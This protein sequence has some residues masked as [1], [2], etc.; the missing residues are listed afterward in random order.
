MGRPSN[1]TSSSSSGSR[2][3][4]LLVCLLLGQML[5]IGTAWGQLRG[6][7]Q[8]VIENV[9]P[10]PYPPDYSR[11]PVFYTS[12]G[13]DYDAFVNEYFMRNL[14]VDATG[15]YF[16]DDDTFSP[17]PG[18]TGV[19]EKINWDA[20]FLPWVDT[21]AMGLQRQPNGLPSN[22]NVFFQDRTLTGLLQTGMG[23]FGYTYNRTGNWLENT[24]RQTSGNAFMWSWPAY[25]DND[26]CSPDPDGDPTG[27]EFQGGGA[28]PAE[29][30]SADFAF[31]DNYQDN[32]LSGTI[33]GPLNRILTPE[34]DCEV[35]HLPL[36][37]IDIKYVTPS[38]LG[39]DELLDHF[40][41]YW[42]RDIDAGFSE[43]RSVGIDFAVA[44]PNDFPGMFVWMVD[45]DSARYSLHFPM[46]LHPEW[47]HRITQ[48]MIKPVEE[49]A[50]VDA[51]GTQVS[52]N[53][54]RATYDLRLPETNASLI[55][56]TYR[57][58]MWGGDRQLK[59]DPDYPMG[60]SF[61]E[62]ML[63]D[64]RRSMLFM[65]EHLR[66]KYPPHLLDFSWMGGHDGDAGPGTQHTGRGQASGYWDLS[67]DG[68]YDLYSST[69]YYYA[70]KAMAEIEAYVEARGIDVGTSQVVGPDNE[71]VI[72]Y[73]E[74]SATLRALAEQVKAGIEQELW[75]ST[76]RFARNI[77]IYGNKIDYGY[78]F[79]NLQALFF[80]IGT[81]TQ[82]SSI[83]QW[84]DGERA[85][86]GDHSHGADIYH[87]RFAP[88]S[89][90]RHNHSYYPWN[91]ANR[92]QG[93]S[94]TPPP[95][96]EC[97]EEDRY[98]SFG[99][100][101]ENGGAVP[102]TSLFDLVTRIRTGDQAQIDRA[103]ERTLEIKD[104]FDDIKAA[105]PPDTPGNLFYNAYYEDRPDRGCLQGGSRGPGGL[106]VD[107]EFASSG[108]M[109]SLFMLYGF[110]GIDAV[111]DSVL[112]VA[113][114]FPTAL[115][116]VGVTNVYYQGNHLTIEAG[117]QPDSQYI[118]FE[119]STIPA[120][121][122][123]QAR[124]RFENLPD[125]FEVTVDNVPVPASA[126]EHDVENRSLTVLVDLAPVRIAVDLLADVELSA[127]PNRGLPPLLVTV[128]ATLTG[129]ITDHLWWVGNDLPFGN[130]TLPFQ[131]V[132]VDP[133][134][135]DV[136]VTV[137]GPWGYYTE[138]WD[139]NIEVLG[140]VPPP[141]DFDFPA[142]FAGW[143]EIGIGKPA[144]TPQ[145][146]LLPIETDAPQLVS[147]P[148]LDLDGSIY[149]TLTLRLRIEGVP[150]SAPAAGKIFFKTERTPTFDG[151]EVDFT[152]PAG[153]NRWHT[154]VADMSAHSA[155]GDPAEGPI[156]QLRV[157]P[158]Y[159]QVGQV[160]HLDRIRSESVGYLAPF[161]V[162]FSQGTEGWNRANLSD[163]VQTS[164][165]IRMEVLSAKPKL[166]SPTDL[167]ING[168]L[169]DTLKIHLR[170]EDDP[171]TA[172]AM[173]RI[174]FGTEQNPTYSGLRQINYTIP[175]GDQWQTIT[176]D[177]GAHG[178]WGNMEEGL[179]TKI[180]IDPIRFRTGRTLHMGAVWVENA[181]TAQ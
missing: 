33:T 122:G 44:P 121:A 92:S 174:F 149:G 22:G 160:I 43:E 120:G 124:L 180:R 175:A 46:H 30:T 15:I 14:S 111:Q 74:T 126:Y 21:G 83:L 113:P 102:F 4:Y 104:W 27:W 169:Y 28:T 85:I 18:T 129:D 146:I 24:A 138:T 5:S 17:T 115:D 6:R 79:D 130:P 116:Q 177:A 110:L 118:S 80:G 20:W 150:L 34:F 151:H 13:G 94:A 3:I 65:N 139:G 60:G 123:L 101:F 137:T 112:D 133:G 158:I 88:R 93:A 68:R 117:R 84:L 159:G 131:S 12:E 48:M 141:V 90:T 108:A 36:V 107:Q 153:A 2:W 119:G 134:L 71:T 157:D 96:S 25:W 106:G 91:W 62:T 7:G 95:S 86:I 161:E 156:T 163:P 73:G 148:G 75:A 1:N 87:W 143:T 42:K 29:W 97:Y 56:A 67:P 66:G 54:I 135:F 100:K 40:K 144:T 145:G 19:L 26:V 162:D 37:T 172:P 64:L 98:F 45:P 99:G 142:D 176:L 76:G 61:L 136:G 178:A 114:A 31:A 170:I 154:L 103:Y 38:G 16:K 109:G 179:I 166:F 77:D 81:E 10:P 63:P 47:S 39:S 105:N 23:K 70:V 168:T 69:H 155:W 72:T 171:L 35:F 132:L 173:G 32:S 152:I 147:P 165:G 11:L 89:S 8:V 41:L 59:P 9:N 50:G 55:Y 57:Y 49:G 140:E 164:E 181:A 53:Y 125:V 127:T 128:D 167:T 78:V 51:T 82:R 52:F 58:L